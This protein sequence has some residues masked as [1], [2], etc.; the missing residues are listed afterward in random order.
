MSLAWPHRL[1][2]ILLVDDQPVNV[3][4]LYQAI[5]ELGDIYF[6]DNGLE[7]L[8]IFQ[9]EQ[10]DLLLLD[11]EMPGMSGF[12]LLSKINAIYPRQHK[13]SVIFITSHQAE[14]YELPAL[15]SG[16]VD[17]LQ[18]PFNLLVAKARINFHLKLRHK[19]N[20]LQLAESR[21]ASIINR[22]P[23]LISTWD[24]DLL[25]VFCNTKLGAWFYGKTGCEPG[26]HLRDFLGERLFA[27]LQTEIMQVLQG[28]NAYAE[29]QFTD[30]NGQERDG[31]IR[32]LKADARSK[33]NGFLMIISD[34]SELKSLGE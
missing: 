11:V 8:A 7:A 2:K 27:S 15:L 25:N 19:S 10:P 33:D 4:I 13:F 17:F 31:E 9:R 26:Q 24:T 20:Q 34:L 21:F 18:K 29:I 1:P 16:A 32:L 23:C 6:A 12:E 14:L 30:A 5:G 22:L 3:Q 28:K